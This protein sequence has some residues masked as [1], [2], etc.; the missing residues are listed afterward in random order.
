MLFKPSPE[1]CQV[2]E[3]LKP[4][5]E[6]IAFLPDF[7][8]IAASVF[9]HSRQ[10]RLRVRLPRIQ[11]IHLVLASADFAQVP[12]VVVKAVAVDVVY[13]HRGKMPVVPSPDDVV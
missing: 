5:A 6:V 9:I 12:D 7:Y 2:V 11:R 10:S 1:Q 8:S 3:C 4:V 13:L